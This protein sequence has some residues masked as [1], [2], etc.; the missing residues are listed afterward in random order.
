[1]EEVFEKDI[2][3][4]VQASLPNVVSWDKLLKDPELTENAIARRYFTT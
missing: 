3:A 2:K 4:V 1:M